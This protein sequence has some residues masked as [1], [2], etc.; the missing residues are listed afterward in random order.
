MVKEPSLVKKF[1]EPLLTMKK[2]SPEIMTSQGL[3]VDWA[4]PCL[5]MAVLI[6]AALAPRPI[7]LALIPPRPVSAL[8]PEAACVVW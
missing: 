3:F 8:A 4:E 5:V 2:D 7:C 6:A 1:W